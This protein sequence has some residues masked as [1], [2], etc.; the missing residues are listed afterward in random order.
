MPIIVDC[1]GCRKR[2][3][4]DAS[5][6]GKKSRCKQCGEVFRL[7]MP[8]GNVVETVTQPK[9]P[10]S[11]QRSAQESF[12]GDKSPAASV[13]RAPA[14]G[15]SVAGHG[16]S[17]GRP[18]SLDC[19]GC[20][21]HYE[22]DAALAGKKSRCK[23]CGEV[24]PIPVP[25][26]IVTE[27]PS[28]PGR[29]TS[30]PPP[31]QPPLIEMELIFGEEPEVFKRAQ[32]YAAPADDEEELPAPSRIAY[33]KP[34]RKPSARRAMDP[35]LGIAVTGW[36]LALNALGIFGLWIFHSVAGPE[37]AIFKVF[38]LIYMVL[39][40]LSHLVLTFWGGI[41]LLVIAFREST[42][43]GW[44]CL[45][46]P[47][48][49]AYYILTRWEDTRGGFC[50]LF[51]SHIPAIVLAVMS[52]LMFGDRD[53]LGANPEKPKVAAK[54][55]P[56]FNNAPVQVEE[57]PAPP[58]AFGP[59]RRPVP[60]PGPFR[61]GQ[62]PRAGR[63]PS[64]GRP[65]FPRM[66][67]PD[68]QLKRIVEEYGDRAVTIVVSGLP[69]NSDPDKGVTNRDA[70]E[71]INKRLRELAPGAT[72]FLSIG[73]SNRSKIFLA[74]VDDI[75][76]FAKSIDFGRVIVKGTLIEVAVSPD[77]I[78]AV[79]RLPTEQRVAAG[80][81]GAPKQEL[82][83]EIPAGADAITKSLIELKSPNTGKKKDA[84][85][86]LERMA[87]DHRVD[88]VVAALLPL[89]DDDDGF[90]VND[91]IK[92]LAVWQSPEV[93]PALIE[94]TKDN[95]FFVRHEA[96]KALGK[97]KD[98]RAVE[99]LIERF[100]EDGFQSEDALKELGSIAEPALIA[101]LRDGNPEIRRKACNILKVI[102]GLETLK[103][104]KS[105]PQDPDFGT[106]VAAN[107]AYKEIESRV[108][109]LPGSTK[110][111]KTGSSSRGRR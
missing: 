105:L 31:S 16:S 75:Q 5:L 45:L 83:P 11:P 67:T 30:P 50:L 34:S 14:T 17:V 46:V 23:Q 55:A 60:G 20:G 92:A 40:S 2:Y 49:Q 53:P 44:L 54:P 3:E 100:K 82:E 73:N 68:Q 51:G 64:P 8:N 15:P 27:L 102:G 98:V 24:F 52:P 110:S 22:V 39:F 86:R 37:P 101:R 42:A 1:P 6:A 58:T 47:C 41:W 76:G 43:Q 7:P 104:M 35:Q 38:V 109:P 48:Y 18:I 93:V 78:A 28:K 107:E 25:M 59:G 62:P 95:R 106:R 19:P 36:Y 84:I 21:K 97:S 63:N 32:S 108:G 69:N 80:N 79:P 99:P 12:L 111:S 96:I 70:S 56:K 61:G 77:Y 88:E 66:E 26:G 33:P 87:P 91:V 85:Q 71:A 10:P 89:L 94:R 57:P 13:S 9:P 74:P 103:A 81:H 29:G 4:V 65:A 72:E 90:L